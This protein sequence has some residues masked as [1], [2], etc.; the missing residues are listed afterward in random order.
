MNVHV[1]AL[2]VPIS[3][4]Q[5]DGLSAAMADD[6][7]DSDFVIG[8]WASASR[9]AIRTLNGDGTETASSDWVQVSRLGMPLT[10]EAVIPIGEKDYWNSIS[11]YADIH[12]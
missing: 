5:K 1:I 8:V 7:L 2:Q 10:N 6:I 12:G 4:L 9:R 3:S 11:P